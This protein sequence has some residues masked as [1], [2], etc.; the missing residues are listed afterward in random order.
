MNK[1]LIATLALLTVS[2]TLVYAAGRRQRTN[3][4]AMLVP[5]SFLQ[6]KEKP[7][8]EFTRTL[9]IGQAL[10]DPAIKTMINQTKEKHNQVKLP[11]TK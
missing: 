8:P 3:E 4:V 10:K 5:W 11:S 2:G 1:L 6:N 9:S 7:K